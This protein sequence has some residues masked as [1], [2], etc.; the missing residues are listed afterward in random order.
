M[1]NLNLNSGKL[2]NI[3]KDLYAIAKSIGYPGDGAVLRIM[4]EIDKAATAMHYQFLIMVTAANVDKGQIEVYYTFIVF[5]LRD[6]TSINLKS[7]LE[8]IQGYYP[9]LKNNAALYSADKA[10]KIIRDSINE[11]ESTM[12]VLLGQ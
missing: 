1:R 9:Y 8:S 12:K 7:T 5:T 4:D 11:M 2:R 3:Q 10:K 6:E